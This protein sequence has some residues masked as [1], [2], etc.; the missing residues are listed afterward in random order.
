MK[1]FHEPLGDVFYYGVERLSE[2]YEDD[3]G[4]R[5]DSGFS[6]TTYK[7][8]F[9]EMEK[10]GSEVGLFPSSSLTCPYPRAYPLSV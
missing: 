2:R 10:G 5:A 7:A 6:N 1:C 4:A 8:I 9:D 3:K